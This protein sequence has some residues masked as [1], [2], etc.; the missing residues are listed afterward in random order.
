VKKF[1]GDRTILVE[2]SLREALL[3]ALDYHGKRHGGFISS[4]F[5]ASYDHHDQQ[6]CAC[7]VRRF[8]A[9]SNLPSRSSKDGAK[10]E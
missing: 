4:N 9:S 6:H 8:S 3:E 5:V 10:S 2:R 1:G 7:G